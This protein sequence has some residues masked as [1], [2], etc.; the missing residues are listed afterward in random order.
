[1]KERSAYLELLASDVIPPETPGTGIFGLKPSAEYHLVKEVRSEETLALYTT[2]LICGH[3]WFRTE[4]C[5]TDN[6]PTIAHPYEYEPIFWRGIWDEA[7]TLTMISGNPTRHNVRVCFLQPKIE[8]KGSYLFLRRWLDFLETRGDVLKGV[9]AEGG[10]NFDPAGQ[11]DSRARDG[12]FRTNNRVAKSIVKMLWDFQECAIVHPRTYDW[13][14]KIAEWDY[15][16]AKQS[17]LL[18]AAAAMQR[19]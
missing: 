8:L 1:M 5:H 18:E 9:N 16:T 14:C 3:H 13:V 19:R 12:I 4:F 15:E 11:H 6:I 17:A 10:V 7:G 2:G